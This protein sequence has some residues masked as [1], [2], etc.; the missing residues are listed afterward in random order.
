MTK[1]KK[2][3]AKNKPVKKGKKEMR[4]EVAA[5]LKKSFV[6]IEKKVGKKK[7]ENKIKKAAKVL[8]KGT[9]KKVKAVKVKVKKKI[10]G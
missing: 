1:V 10:S 7:F 9:T 3:P 8:A 5:T 6:E 4:E 2:A